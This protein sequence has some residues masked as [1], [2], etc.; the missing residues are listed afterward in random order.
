MATTHTVVKGDTLSELAV[1]YNTTV[2]KLASL[3]NIK[4]VDLIYIGQVLKIDGTA[5]PVKT[6]VTSKAVITAFGFQANSTNTIFAT[7]SWDRGNTEHYQVKWYYDTGNGVWFIGTD[8]TVTEKQ[9]TYN[10]PDNAKRVKFIVKPVSKTKTVNNKQT[11]YWSASWSTAKYYNVSD[12]PPKTPPVPTPSIKDYKLTATLDN[13]DVNATH[14]TFQ[15]FKNNVTKTV[16]KSA[17]VSI[18][19]N[20]ASATWTVD[21]GAEYCIRAQSIKGSQKSDWSNYSSNAA[22]KPST[23]SKITSIKAMSKT[24][25]SLAWS[26]VKTATSYDIEYATKKSYFDTTDQTTTKTSTTNSY[27]LT[28]LESGHEYFVRVR[29]SNDAGDKSGW[30]EIKSVVIGS[31]PS[32]PTT[33]S[34]TETV[35]VG[36]ILTLYWVHNAEDGSDQTYAEVELVANGVKETYT[37]RPDPN[38][39]ED[40]EVKTYSYPIDTSGYSEGT[41]VEWRVRTAGVT[42]TYGEWSIQRM[43][44]IYAPPT[45]SLIVTD[46]NGNDLDTLAAFPIK[47]EAIAGPDTQTPISYHLTVVSN[48]IYETVDEVG[49]VKMVNV[50]E[51]VYSQHFDI[52]R[53]LKIDLLANDIDL[54]N[55][56]SYTTKCIV[57]MNSGLTATETKEFS[58]AWAEVSYEPNA[59]IIFDEETFVAHIR[60]YCEDENGTVIDDISLFV[61]RRNND[62]SFIEIGGDIDNNASTFVT[63]PH[64]TLDC[65]RYRIVARTNSTGAIGY[66]DVSCT[67]TGITGVIIQ[68]DEEWSSF[69]GTEDSEYE[70]PPWSGS[71]LIMPY[72]ID[73]ADKSAPDVSLIEYIGRK[74]PVSYYGTQVGASSTWNVL[75]DSKDEETINGLRRLQAWMGDVYVREPLGSGYWASITVT[76]PQ[77]HTEV[78]VPVTI[79]ITRVEGGI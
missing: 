31:D 36:D 62:G 9:S 47:I 1:K 3:N 63:D 13:L 74:H 14:I 39:D 16:Y 50:G 43:V 78:A 11:S 55:N 24:S 29:A 70:Q 10:Y 37:I 23:P 57:A 21:A 8:T 42:N 77:K 66:G 2:S 60:P 45:L 79:D 65:A 71:M 17:K 32:A 34:S 6:N 64:P 26:A 48:E 30:S 59:E 49:R 56:V 7:W 61:Y 27:E 58:V 5:D 67:P 20:R 38:E 4:N 35:I 44:N 53:D 68:W 25:I 46:A 69:Y 51:E 22:T 33:W 28:N 54:A 75:I 40:D 73:V 15:V 19:G 52:T 76:F 41:T 12:A 72:N 18:S